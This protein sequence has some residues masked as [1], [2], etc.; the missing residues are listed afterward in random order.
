MNATATSSP[1]REPVMWLVVG[2][3]LAVVLASVYL[4]VKLFGGPPLDAVRDEVQRV[5][6]AQVTDLA[7]DQRAQQMGIGMLLSVLGD[8]IEVR[9]AAGDLPVAGNLRLVLAHPLD[10]SQDREL[11]LQ[12][13]G[14]AWHATA[15]L[16]SDHD[17]N[18]TLS[19]ADGSWRLRGRL[20]RNARAAILQPALSAP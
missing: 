15:Q 6:Q 18:V 2:L 10:A 17:W 13:A 16:A 4:M 7:P 19:A 5:S 11:D 1:W 8:R 3:P 14:D 20:V 9:M 12:S